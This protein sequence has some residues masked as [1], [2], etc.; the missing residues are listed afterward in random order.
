MSFSA[1]TVRTLPHRPHAACKARKRVN[2]PEVDH[3]MI[4]EARSAVV[5]WIAAEAAGRV[6]CVLSLEENDG[7]VIRPFTAPP[8]ERHRRI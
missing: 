5:F 1:S 7:S 2:S 6:Y 4:D 3:Y 8:R